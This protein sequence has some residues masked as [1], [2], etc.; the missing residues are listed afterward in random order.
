MAQIENVFGL[1]FPELVSV[2][3]MLMLIS[4][5]MKCAEDSMLYMGK[6]VSVTKTCFGRGSIQYL[7]R[8]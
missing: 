3:E 8:L 6:I 7:E 4:Q 2:N 5:S 1:N